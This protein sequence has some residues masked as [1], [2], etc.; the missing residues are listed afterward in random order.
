[1]GCFGETEFI[2]GYFAMFILLTQLGGLGNWDS[3]LSGEVSGY[4]LPVL[5]FSS[6]GCSGVLWLV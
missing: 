4:A 1:M 5:V 2:E 6:A 3:P